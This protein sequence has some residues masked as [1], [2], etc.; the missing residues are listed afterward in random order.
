MTDL[1]SPTQAQFLEDVKDH[2]M[3]VLKDDGADMISLVDQAMQYTRHYIWHCRAIVWAIQQYDKTER[4]E[5]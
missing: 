5:K 4:I 3:T 1:Y 2:E